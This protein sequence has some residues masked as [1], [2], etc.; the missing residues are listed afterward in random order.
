MKSFTRMI[1]KTAKSI[2][3]INIWIRLFV[4]LGVL[5]LVLNY[6][7]YHHPFPEG[8]TIGDIWGGN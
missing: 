4:F 6:I 3:K 1:K 5:F 7:N 2:S 8:F